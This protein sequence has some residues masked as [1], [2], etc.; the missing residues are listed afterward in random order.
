VKAFANAPANADVV[1]VV[2]SATSSSFTV[3]YGGIMDWASHPFDEGDNLFLSEDDTGYLVNANVTTINAVSKPVG[4]VTTSNEILVFPQRGIQNTV[5]GSG[6]SGSGGFTDDGT[7]VR[8]TTITDKVGIGTTSPS[9]ILTVAGNISSRNIIYDGC[10]NSQKYCSTWGSTNSLS[11]EWEKA[12]TTLRANSAD[13]SYVAE[14]SGS[15]GGSGHTI[16]YHHNNLTART[17]LNFL[18]SGGVTHLSACDAGSSP[19]RTNVV[20][21]NAFDIAMIGEVFR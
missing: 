5:V 7:V 11:A 20:A 2:E 14:N 18:S 12:K 17:D 3:V 21:P 10:G 4:Q 9:E 16:E 8:L 19:N 15:G 1:G 13:W 6:G